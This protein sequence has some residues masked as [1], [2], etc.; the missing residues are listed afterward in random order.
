MKIVLCLFAASVIY[1]HYSPAW[2]V[3]WPAMIFCFVYFTISALIIGLPLALLFRHIVP[4]D[5]FLLKSA[6]FFFWFQVSF[7][8]PLVVFR[9][10]QIWLAGN[11]KLS[12]WGEGALFMDGELTESGFSWILTDALSMSFACIFA[13]L[14]VISAEYKTQR[15]KMR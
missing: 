12:Q 15:M 14:I 1:T 3:T 7:L 2:D 6:A 11:K 4:K 10:F 8:T 9:A 5:S 13:A